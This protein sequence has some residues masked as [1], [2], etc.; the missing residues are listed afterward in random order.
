MLISRNIQ[1]TNYNTE[2][3]LHEAKV[4]DDD[5]NAQEDI[6]Y[7]YNNRRRHAETQSLQDD[8]LQDSMFD[9]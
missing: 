2:S 7:E 8:S 6:H 5:L 3:G 9:I 1:N 4:F